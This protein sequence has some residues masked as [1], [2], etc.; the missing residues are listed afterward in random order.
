LPSALLL[1]RFNG[2]QDNK[3]RIW[4]KA[5]WATMSRDMSREEKY[6]THI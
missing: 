1:L 4:N 5:E 6:L 2:L 3:T